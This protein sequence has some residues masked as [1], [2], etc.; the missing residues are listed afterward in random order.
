MEKSGE[1]V[2]ATNGEWGLI[3]EQ[4]CRMRGK[5]LLMGG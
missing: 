3:N 2:D 5:S 4:K 1:G